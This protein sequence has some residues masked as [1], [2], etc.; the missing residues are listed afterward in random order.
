MSTKQKTVGIN[1]TRELL[2]SSKIIESEEEN[3][4][5]LKNFVDSV[6]GNDVSFTSFKKLD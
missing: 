3:N 1:D 6:A 2:E 4:Q 5:R